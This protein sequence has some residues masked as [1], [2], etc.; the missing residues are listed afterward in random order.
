GKVVVYYNLRKRVD[1]LVTLGLFE[2]D[3]FYREIVD[4]KK[5]EVLEVFRTGKTRVVVATSALGIGVD[6]ADIRLIIH[7]DKLRDL[8]DY[9]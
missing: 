4:R 1:R 3:R 9:I 6:I 8:L 2:C 7:A 5:L